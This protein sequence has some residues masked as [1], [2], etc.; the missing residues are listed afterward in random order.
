VINFVRY[1]ELPLVGVVIGLIALAYRDVLRRISHCERV[2]EKLIPQITEIGVD[3]KYIR[4]CCINCP[5]KI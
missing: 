3:V 4:A 2:D 5:E 1:A